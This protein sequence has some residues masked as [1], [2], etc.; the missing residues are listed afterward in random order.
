MKKQYWIQEATEGHGNYRASVK[1]RY[2]KK[3]FSKQGTIK[4]EIIN[5][6]VKK[7]GKLGKQA[8]LA[9]TLKGLAH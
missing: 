7:A 9:K 3:G 8:R 5:K 6:D 2:G 4:T 1:R